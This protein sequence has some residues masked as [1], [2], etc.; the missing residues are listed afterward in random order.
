MQKE[1]VQPDKV[2]LR[3]T[4]QL[5]EPLQPFTLDYDGRYPVAFFDKSL[6]GQSCRHPCP[7]MVRRAPRSAN[8]SATLQC[9]RARLVSQPEREAQQPHQGLGEPQHPPTLDSASSSGYTFGPKDHAGCPSAIH[10]YPQALDRAPG[11]PLSVGSVSQA[12][13]GP[14]TSR[15]P[16]G[17]SIGVLTLLLEGLFTDHTVPTPAI[18]ITLNLSVGFAKRP[19]GPTT[20]AFSPTGPRRKPYEL[21]PVIRSQNHP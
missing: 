18:T 15:H 12:M 1:G 3:S 5:T 20:P 14:A 17:Y 6:V 16:E 19:V 11:R 9:I 8:S 13:S 7:L 4:A 10:S 2:S 21:Q